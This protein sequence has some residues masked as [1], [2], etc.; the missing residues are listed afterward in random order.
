MFVVYIFVTRPLH[1]GQGGEENGP[2]LREVLRAYTVKGSVNA[3]PN[4]TD[5]LFYAYIRIPSIKQ[6]VFYRKVPNKVITNGFGYQVGEGNIK[7]L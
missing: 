7:W 5:Y 2:L 6:C 3:L 1:Y 4:I